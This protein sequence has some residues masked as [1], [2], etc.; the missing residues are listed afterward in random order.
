MAAWA[1]P[2]EVSRAGR[3]LELNHYRVLNII[4]VAVVIHGFMH[5]YYHMYH[6]MHQLINQLISMYLE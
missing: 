6:F 4:V 3:L 2:T 1:A 5:A